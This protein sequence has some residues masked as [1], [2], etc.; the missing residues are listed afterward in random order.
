MVSADQTD[1]RVGD[2]QSVKETEANLNLSL[3]AILSLSGGE[4]G[5]DFIEDEM[6]NFHRMLFNLR[7]QG[8]RQVEVDVEIPADKE[9]RT[10]RQFVEHSADALAHEDERY[11]VDLLRTQLAS[12]GVADTGNL[13]RAT[14]RVPPPSPDALTMMVDERFNHSPHLPILGLMPRPDGEDPGGYPVPLK[15][16]KGIRLV[17]TPTQPN[18][19]EPPMQPHR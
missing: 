19:P 11:V 14:L 17:T 16:V 15:F 4:D 10:R 9:Y 12:Q 13:M 5:E 6:A 2:P 7:F 18:S 3:F 1:R 8:V